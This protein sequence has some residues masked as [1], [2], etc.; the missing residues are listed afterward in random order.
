MDRLTKALIDISKESQDEYQVVFLGNYIDKGNNSK[1]CIS[2]LIEFSKKWK[3]V[4]FLLGK[5]EELLSSL[6]DK[7]YVNKHS[8]LVN[9][10]A[11]DIKQ[12]WFRNGGDKTIES[13][14]N[15]ESE[16]FEDVL[17]NIKNKHIGFFESL[18]QIYIQRR[19][20]FVSS[21]INKRIPLN[22]NT[23][24][25][26]LWERPPFGFLYESQRLLVHGNTQCKTVKMNT[27]EMSL[28]VNTGCYSDNGRL[29]IVYITENGQIEKLN[30][31]K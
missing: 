29:S 30:T 13:Y 19:M 26:F 25:N 21:G 16:T 1:E 18:E 17:N 9:E 20:I 22:Q 27:V 4:K 31:Y 15:N 3:N 5:S 12:I 10:K 11:E 6:I 23:I 2:T 7:K 8:I 24:Y 28:N 14:R